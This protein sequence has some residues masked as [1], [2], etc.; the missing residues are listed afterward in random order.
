LWVV[1]NP[2]PFGP[3]LQFVFKTGYGQEFEFDLLQKDC[4]TPITDTPFYLD[5]YDDWRFQDNLAEKGY[6]HFFRTNPELI[7]SNSIYNQKTGSVD[8]CAVARLK[9]SNAKYEEV[10]EIMYQPKGTFKFMNSRTSGNAIFANYV[11]K[12]DRVDDVNAQLLQSDCSSPILDTTIS[13]GLQQWG[14]DHIYD[15]VSFNYTLDST[16]VRDSAIFSKAASAIEVCHVVW[17]GNSNKRD[18]Q[19]IKIP[20]REPGTFAGLF[21]DPH[22]R[23]FDGLQYDCQGKQTLTPSW[24]P[25]FNQPSNSILNI[26]LTDN[27]CWR[28]YYPDILRRSYL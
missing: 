24:T 12:G 7:E 8:I 26:S 6:N 5:F 11:V 13:D 20:L 10:F 18:K 27:S 22:I 17:L 16:T 28:V 2:T 4:T 9:N 14:W 15:Y 3:I 25:W 21:G 19:I 1:V 23:T